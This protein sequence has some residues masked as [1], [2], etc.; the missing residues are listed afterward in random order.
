MF[1][2]KRHIK[3]VRLITLLWFVLF[4]LSS[5]TVKEVVFHSVNKEYTKPLNKSK[6]TIQAGSCSYFQDENQQVLVAKQSKIIQ[7]AQLDDFI[8]SPY[9]Y[10][11]STKTL[12]NYLT[13]FSDNSPPKYILFKRLKIDLV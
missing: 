13:T 3:K 2:I 9:F 4:S 5:C 7:Q 8:V 10:P 1:K 6:T 12:T 11:H